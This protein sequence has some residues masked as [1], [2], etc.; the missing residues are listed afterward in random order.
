MVMTEAKI[1]IGTLIN[2]RYQIQD[3][4]GQGGFGRTYLA[5]DIERFD[6]QCVLKEFVPTYTKRYEVQKAR[7]LFE[8]EARILYKINHPQIPKFLAWFE[9]AESLFIVQEYIN[10]ETYFRLLNDR[11]AQQ[12]QPFSPSEVSQWL[13]TLLPVLDYLHNHDIVHRDISPDNI[14]LPNGQWQPML[15]DFGLVKQRVSQIWSITSNNVSPLPESSFVGKIGYSPP[16]QVR[17][18][19]CYPCSDLYSLAVSAIVLLTGKEPGALMDRSLEWQWRSQVEVDD[20]LGD[21]LTKMLSEKP[22]D[23]Y[24]SAAEILALLQPA[25]AAQYSDGLAL[26]LE[27]EIDETD[28]NQQIAE[29]EET[30]YFKELQAQADALRNDLYSDLAPQDASVYPD[31]PFDGA[32]VTHADSSIF[33][34]LSP[35]HAPDLAPDLVPDLVPNLAPAEAGAQL[36]TDFLD[37]CQHSL[38]RYIGVVAGC[39]VEDT[40]A[41]HPDLSPAQLIVAL[42][43]EIPHPQQAA[44]FT[45]SMAAALAPPI[46]PAFSREPTVSRDRQVFE[47]LPPERAPEFTPELESEFT[48]ELAPE[49]ASSQLDATFL[50]HC[51]QALSRYIGMMAP[52]ILEDTLYDYPDLSPGQLIDALAAAIPNRQQAKEFQQRLT[53]ELVALVTPPPLPVRQSDRT[54]GPQ[55]S[56][57]TAPPSGRSLQPDLTPQLTPAF[58]KQC[59]QE[60]TRCIGPM[61]KY[62]VEETLEQ[63]DHLSGQQLIETLAG[64][65]PNA[66]QAQEFRQRLI[67]S[68]NA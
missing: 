64:A 4:L 36:G 9:E 67:V 13:Q 10:G 44:E 7:D 25:P 56:F 42:A 26:T 43:A 18:G 24:Q 61:A 51:Q 17:M 12:G 8:R 21:I 46:I 65:I 20:R 41:D 50:Q 35:D 45:Q 53:A 58:T 47:V 57:S 1:G 63:N 2:N 19:Q 66:K 23:R 28:K 5:S 31:F 39:V 48:P 16:E 37:H 40:I 14:M 68:L 27:I 52:C 62:I 3:V 49:R 15:I 34:A 38:S 55:S 11:L 32:T 59:Q 22:D 30:D 29:I 60:L 6:E 54:L 33:E